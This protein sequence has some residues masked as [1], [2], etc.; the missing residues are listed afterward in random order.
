MSRR[1]AIVR[2]RALATAVILVGIALGST[3]CGAVHARKAPLRNGLRAFQERFAAARYW[4]AGAAKVLDRNRLNDL[5]A[6]NPATAA[7]RLEAQTDQRPE[8]GAA[9]TLAGLYYRA[10][11]AAPRRDKTAAMLRFRD[12]A[13]L[14]SVALSEPGLPSREEAI[15]LHNRATTHLIGLASEGADE[16]GAWQ[17]ALASV[18]VQL[19]TTPAASHARPERFES[20]TPTEQLRI[21]R[22]QHEYKSWGLGVP[23]VGVRKTDANDP[24]VQERYFPRNFHIGATAMMVPGGGLAG[25][26][27]R[28]GTAR[29]VLHDPS[30]DVPLSVAGR[31]LPM[32]TDKTTPLISQVD[33]RT[34][35]TLE[36][37]GLLTSDFARNGAG[38]TD[39]GIYMLQPYRPGKIPVVLVH[40]LVSSPRAWVQ[41]LNE[42]NSDPALSRHYQFWVFLY[43]TG[44]PIPSNADA[45]RQALY[46]AQGDFD[47]AGKDPAFG[48]TVLVGHSMGGV[49]SKMMIQDSG[50]ALWDATI[51]VPF[52]QLKAPEGVRE[53]LGRI[54]IY[55]PVPFVGRVV[56]V[57][58]PHRGSP[59]ADEPF[60]RAI[61]NLIR[62]TSEQ[63]ETF[64]V[65]EAMNG[66]DVVA[67]ELRGRRSIN[68]VNNLSQRC[69]M[70]K[71]M[72]GMPLAP[73]VPYHTIAYFLG[74]RVPYDLLVSY[75]SAHIEGSAS[76]V[77]LPGTHFS[78][79]SLETTNE[80]RKILI[81]HVGGLA[82][83]PLAVARP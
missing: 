3:G 65:L 75:S 56:C 68:S 27:W 45:L 81:E 6:S 5:A 76:E 63:E 7:A 29:L 21:T 4:E 32:A 60:G 14:A 13:V 74:G 18:G 1:V 82:A 39:S 30:E 54:L 24:D 12:A 22:A 57:A 44:K 46:K 64:E 28:S 19:A 9:L 51:S 17:A 37:A 61:S 38:P 43:P 69:P 78:Q 71:A 52:D 62:G 15:T 40:G 42:L 66:R 26:A 33:G 8:G 73:G 34:L 36:L 20:V 83:N 53:R 50:M 70:L 16:P 31:S 55:K 77:V 58:A 59:F 10:G 67:P 11:L 41:T 80:V 49:I 47:P 23:I 35:A 48:R 25:G 2:K 72:D 79:Q